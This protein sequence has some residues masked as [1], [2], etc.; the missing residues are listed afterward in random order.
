[1]H[2]QWFPGHMTKAIR[3][4]EEN[5]RL[6]D[7]LIYVIDARA[8]Y[9]CAN[10]LLDKL[11]AGK[12]VLYVFNKCDLV[13]KQDLDKWI[14]LY[15]KLGKPCVKVVGTSGDCGV[16]V[17]KLKEINAYKLQRFADKGAKVNVRAMVVGVPNSGKSTI[18]NSMVGKAKAV[19]GDRP[20][21]TRGKQWLSIDGVDFLDTPG[22]LWG[23][24]EDQKVAH[25]LAYIGSIR[26]DI[27][28]TGDLCFDF[29]EEIKE[30]YPQNLIDRY[31]L[32]EMPEGTLELMDAIALS[33][34]YKIRGGEV[35]YDR[36]AR[37]VIDDFRKGRLGKI[38]LEK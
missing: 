19:T 35:D 24:F 11:I 1:M 18:I 10:P 3:M 9:S 12:N 38:I 31:N 22:T 25:H 33:R 34:G 28:D 13:D 4:M 6:V 7:S 21:V 30:S 27:L 32:K 5:L 15:D 2:I 8:V 36:T 26:D 17:K 37:T 14:A 20:G 29:L 16:I 23:K